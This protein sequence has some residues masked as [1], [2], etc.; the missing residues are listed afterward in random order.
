MLLSLWI[1][2]LFGFDISGA[3]YNCCITLAQMFRKTKTKMGS[4]RL[5]G[6]MYIIG[7]V[8]GGFISGAAIKLLSEKCDLVQNDHPQII[9][10]WE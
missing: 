7:S 8:L 9:E 6:I 2:T 5:L 1:I 10:G 3:H 4:S